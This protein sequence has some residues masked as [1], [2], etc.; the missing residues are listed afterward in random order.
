MNIDINDP[1]IT[2]FALGELTGSDAAELA[3]AVRS[4]MNIRQAVEEV[5]DTAALLHG[6]IGGGEVHLLTPE[7]RETIRSAGNDGSAMLMAASSK[8][9]PFWRRPAVAAIGAAA[10]VALGVFMTQQRGGNATQVADHAS[11]WDWSQV[12]MKDLTSPVQLDGGG[13]V[14]A[15][16]AE[17]ASA[18]AVASAMSEDTASFRQE[19][20]K[21]INKEDIKSLPVLP[22]LKEQDWIA[23]D[24]RENMTVNIPLTSGA[25]SWPLLQRYIGEMSTLPPSSAV[26]IEE[27]V[28][29]FNYKF[30]TMLKG[31]GLV[32]DIE[33]CHTPWNPKTL[34]LAVHLRA[35]SPVSLGGEA[36]LTFNARQTQRAR[37]LGYSGLVSNAAKSKPRY[38]SQSHGNY[39]IYELECGVGNHPDQ[40]IATLQIGQQGDELKVRSGQ[41]KSWGDASVDL[42]FASTVTAAGMLLSGT[43]SLG[44]LDSERLFSLLGLLEQGDSALSLGER[45]RA[46]PLLKRAAEL[47][48]QSPQT[49]D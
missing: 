19:L 2:A 11:S 48:N 32:G 33:I 43:T 42:R 25:T 40:V 39:V 9:V 44:E 3:R 37:I 34:L 46:L 41:V 17:D 29:H 22:E 12:D 38:V 36:G 5:R 16:H 10:A 15:S 23:L 8:E 35:V 1:R 24:G 21:R 14:R 28:N 7:Q 26:R 4:D 13:H 31:S 6:T 45:S 47:L 18:T 20:E 27:M 30:P 49:G